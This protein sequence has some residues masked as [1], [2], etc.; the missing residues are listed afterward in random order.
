MTQPRTW[1]QEG[2]TRTKGR[3]KAEAGVCRSVFSVL[4]RHPASFST[5]LIV[6]VLAALLEGLGIGVIIALLQD[7]QAGPDSLVAIPLLESVGRW[8][9]DLTLLHRVRFVAV[10]LIA[11]VLLRGVFSYFSRVLAVL[12]RAKV[13]GDLRHRVFRQSLAVDLGFIERQRFGTL[14]TL[15]NNYPGR[16]GRLVQFLAEGI[17]HLFTA[18]ILVALMLSVSWELTLVAMM[19]LLCTTLFLRGR[20]S[21]QVKQAGRDINEAM[22]QLSH[23][24]IEGLS[25]IRLIHLVSQEHR[26]ISRFADALDDY[27]AALYRRGQLVS[28]TRPLYSS[29]NVIVLSLMLIAGSFFL[30]GQIDVWLGHLVVFL[31]IVLRL[32]P[33]VAALAS[34]RAQVNSLFPALRDVLDFVRPGIKPYLKNGRVRLNTL[35]E[36]VALEGVTFGY[37]PHEALVLKDVTFEVPKGRMTAVVGASGA[38]KTTLV[39]LIARLYDCTRGRVTV[40]G[41][42]VRDL[43]IASWHGHVAVVSQDAFVFNDS[44]RANIRFGQEDAT[45]EEVRQAARLANACDFIDSLPLGYETVLG[46]RGVRLSGGQ[47]QRIAIARAMLS[48]PQLL[49]L[50][51]ATSHLDTETERSIQEA[52][53]R[54]R[55]DRTV[56]VVAHRLST[57][58]HADNIVVLDGGSVA[59]QG[60]HE[61]LM[62]RHGR[63]WQLAQAQSLEE[64]RPKASGPE[65]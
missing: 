3:A 5:L 31:V 64:G 15:L 52:I 61:H 56:L 20:L 47:R 36:G 21:R 65:C 63:Y 2:Q 6:S 35:S 7:P 60:T 33:P 12:L 13:D 57:I 11:V 10:A 53:D 46:D 50:D 59:E 30:P 44:V 40:D 43:D 54:I 19:L 8:L 1:R 16:A 25:A 62:R 38:G 28:L 39:N 26:T 27:R 48:D 32:L 18:A 49:I 37:D 29:L 14:V 51:E 41:V 45:E 4:A 9:S 42:D 23:L 34:A 55:Q 58:R 22:A 17:S 24:G